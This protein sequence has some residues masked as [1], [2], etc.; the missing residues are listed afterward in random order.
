[1]DMGYI[2]KAS[3]E[4]KYIDY[5][6]LVEETISKIIVGNLP[7]SAWDGVLDGWYKN[8]GKEYVKEMNDFI[9]SNNK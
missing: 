8:G 1:M 6:K 2:P 4:Q 3:K 7:V 9:K 5:Q